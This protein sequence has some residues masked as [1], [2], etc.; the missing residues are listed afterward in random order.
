MAP[1]AEEKINPS[2]QHEHKKEYFIP[3]ET[4]GGTL[5]FRIVKR[6]F[7]FTAA[8]VGLLVAAIPMAVV[9]VM[10]RLDS[11]G[12]AIYKQERLGKGGKPFNMY[13]FRSMRQDAEENGAQW[14]EEDDPRVTRIGKIIRKTRLD[15]LP[16]LV[17]I[18][19]GH[20]S[21]VGP[22]PERGIFYK[23]F[24]TYVHGFSNRLAV[25]PGLTGLA[26]VNG[27]YDLKPEEKVIYDMEYIRNQSLL[28]DL[29][30]ILQ[31]VGIVFSHDGA[32]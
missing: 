8:A 7:D 13:K 3:A 29:K 16:Q 10:I 22:R 4:P 21:V 28:L 11:P 1:T 24:E 18:L 25:T 30:C 23:E 19:A 27:G 2:S 26:Q 6:L 20:M 31:T 12:P 17:N 15:E 32:R 9:A 14:A 5:G